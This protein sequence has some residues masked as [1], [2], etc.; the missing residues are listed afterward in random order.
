M[1]SY[2]GNFENEEDM[3][4]KLDTNHIADADCGTALRSFVNIFGKYDTQAKK[5]FKTC[6]EIITDE[7]VDQEKIYEKIDKSIDNLLSF[8][9][10]AEDR[11]YADLKQQVKIEE[12]EKEAADAAAAA[13]VEAAKSQ[14][15]KKSLEAPPSIRVS[16][17]LAPVESPDIRVQEGGLSPDMIMAKNDH[18][19]SKSS[20]KSNNVLSHSKMS[21]GGLSISKR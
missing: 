4:T 8:K 6:V 16:P 13:A 14:G 7:K 10:I 19:L 20:L 18:M 3:M 2:Y 17:D 15:S 5:G 1:H 12:L 21:Q 11:I 9:Q